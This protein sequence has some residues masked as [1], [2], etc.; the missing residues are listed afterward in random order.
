MNKLDK[1]KLLIGKLD[2]RDLT[3]LL[4]YIRLKSDIIIPKCY[5]KEEVMSMVL[6]EGLSEKLND[7]DFTCLKNE[8]DNGCKEIMSEVL[9]TRLMV[10][11]DK[12]QE[13]ISEN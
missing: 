2:N 11:L 6:T 5:T 4:D 9:R 8:F 3:R 1:V 13:I 12:S 7:S 10:S